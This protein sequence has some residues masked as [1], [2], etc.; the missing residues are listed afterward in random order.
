MKPVDAVDDKYRLGGQ[1][2]NASEPIDG[3]DE[4]PVRLRDLLDQKRKIVQS[5]R[6]S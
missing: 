6:T 1:K 2:I 5:G 3:A 4:L